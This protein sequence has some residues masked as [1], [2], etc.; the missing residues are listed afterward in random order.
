VDPLARAQF[1]D[2]ID[3]IRADRPGMSVIVATAYMDEAQRFDWLAAI[4]DGK[5]L[6]TGTPK[7]LLE[8]T[9]SPNLEE[10]FIRLLPEE[11]KRGHQ[12]VVI[13]PCRMAARTISPS[14]RKGLTMRFGDFV[15]VDQRVLPHPA[16]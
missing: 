12:A 1:W 2:L 6:A 7:E 4:D 3:R 14:K 8:T 9:G 5:V 11:K 13:P 10:A 16:R 15:A